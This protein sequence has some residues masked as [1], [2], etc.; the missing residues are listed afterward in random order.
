MHVKV[1][2]KYVD[3]ARFKVVSKKLLLRILL[4]FNMRVQWFLSQLQFHY[5]VQLNLHQKGLGFSLNERSFS[6]FF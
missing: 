5:N 1:D 6:M 2:W 4:I 3:T